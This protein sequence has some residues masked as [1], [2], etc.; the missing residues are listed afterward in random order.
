MNLDDLLDETVTYANFLIDV[1]IRQESAASLGALCNDIARHY[2]A[3]GIYDLLLHADVGGFH[4]GLIQSAL[5]R[6]YY[7][8]RCAREGHF[9]DPHRRAG[10]A[11]PFL[12]A[13]A[14]GQLVLASRIAELS[15]EAWMEGYEYEDDFAYA[16]FLYQLARPDGGDPSIRARRLDQF[17]SALQ[18]QP[19]DRLQVAR[20]LEA[21]DQAG[22]DEAFADLLRARE[23][24]MEVLA[25]PEVD[26][27]RAKEAAFAAN[28][29]VFVEGLALLR[30]AERQ[31]VRTE[32]QYTFCPD[33]A[34]LPSPEPF[35]SASFPNLA[36]A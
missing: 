24:E 5:T 28:R 12:D 1:A 36:L 4:H 31:G 22:F 34:R 30:L 26:S 33:L 25:D 13:V 27:A 32:P 11:E 19:S 2:R 6:Q 7:L 17:E 8:G 20:A 9:E 18:G 16:T 10:F 29:W 35:V 15:P 23:A 3:M 14:V 21:R